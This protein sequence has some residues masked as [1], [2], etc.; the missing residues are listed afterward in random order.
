MV[1]LFA[2]FPRFEPLWGAPETQRGRSGLSD[3]VSLSD[4]QSPQIDESVAIE[5]RGA[6]AGDSTP[7][8]WYFRAMVLE[9]FDGESW[10][11]AP[12]RPATRAEPQDHEGALTG[13]A[14]VTHEV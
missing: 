14:Q 5:V 2:L 6:G 1:L 10:E 4:L 7:D 8:Q 13:R 3:S 12:S 11:A 9:Q